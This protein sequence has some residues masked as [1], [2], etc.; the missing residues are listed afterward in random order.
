MTDTEARKLQHGIEVW[1]GEIWNN[2]TP[3]TWR[4]KVT[5]VCGDR[6]SARCEIGGYPRAANE[7]HRTEEE[8]RLYVAGLLSQRIADL[9]QQVAAW[10]AETEAKRKTGNLS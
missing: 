9:E 8:A 3:S 6:L 2:G 1:V 10:N 4:G 7:I 5:A